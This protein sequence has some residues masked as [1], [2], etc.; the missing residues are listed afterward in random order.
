MVQLLVLQRAL[1]EAKFSPQPRDTALPGSSILAELSVSVLAEIRDR[2]AKEGKLGYVRRWSEWGRWSRRTEEQ[3]M[4]YEFLRKSQAWSDMSY[5]R[6]RDGVLAL[7]AP[8]EA[9]E[10]EI[11]NIIESVQ[12]D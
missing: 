3:A 7:I 11:T 2:Y 4:V 5:P 8:F 6:R 1:L 9:T 10:E 12:R